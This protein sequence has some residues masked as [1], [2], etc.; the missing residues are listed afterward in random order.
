MALPLTRFGNSI[1]NVFAL[2]G[3][4]ENSATGAVGWA[5]SQ[6][7][8]FLTRLLADL[9]PGVSPTS[10]RIELQR[11]ADDAGFTDIEIHGADLHLVIEAKVG[12]AVPSRAQLERY[13]DRMGKVPSRLLVSVSNAPA[14]YATSLLP[15]LVGGVKLVHRSWRTIQV[16]ARAAAVAATSP[17]E[18]LWLRQLEH[19]LENYV[20][21]RRATDNTVYVVS[22][23]TQPIKKARTYTWVHVVEDGCYFHPVGKG[24][25]PEPPNYIGFR[26]GGK[27][28]SVHRVEDWM[29]VGQ[30]QIVHPEW[31]SARVPHLVYSLGP[32]MVPAAEI[33]TGKVFKAARVYVAIDLLL[34][35]ECE[36]ISEAVAKTKLRLAS[37]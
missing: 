32:A 29:I 34:S 33:R 11:R 12:L 17:I 31:P 35:G 5:L 36:T 6:C 10:L 20:T 2:A 18:K 9:M 14:A 15:G 16:H 30:P 7:P 3:E 25:P 19:H 24:W 28:Q 21:S 23:R 26:F 37:D 22:L 13:V 4:N 27:L 1:G 8:A